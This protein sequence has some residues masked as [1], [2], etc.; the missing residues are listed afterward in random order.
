L[1]HRVRRTDGSFTW[2]LSR[3]VPIL[4]VDGNVVEWF[5]A[6]SEIT[7]RNEAEQT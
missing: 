5:G 6:A 7:Q 2:A 1:K 3:A 4:G